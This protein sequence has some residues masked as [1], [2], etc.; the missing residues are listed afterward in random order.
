[1]STYQLAPFFNCSHLAVKG[2]MR[3][4]LRHPIY[5]VYVATKGGP[6]AFAFEAGNNTEYYS[7]RSTD[8]NHHG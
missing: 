2:R 3:P 6:E 8:A 7:V 4:H 5:L 1:V